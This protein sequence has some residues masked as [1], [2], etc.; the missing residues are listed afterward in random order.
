LFGWLR[1]VRENIKFAHSEKDAIP[2]DLILYILINNKNNN[3]NNKLSID[4]H[5]TL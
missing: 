4:N 1:F 5:C 3:N 2:Q